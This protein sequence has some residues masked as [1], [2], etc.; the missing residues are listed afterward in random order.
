M[1]LKRVHHVSSL[2]KFLINVSTASR[3]P[4]NLFTS[5][6]PFCC[7]GRNKVGAN[8]TAKFLNVILFRLLCAILKRAHHIIW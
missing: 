7:G 5:I 4:G 2:L 6:S 3:C 8:T 1:K